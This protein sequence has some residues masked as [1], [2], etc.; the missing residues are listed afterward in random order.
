MKL[1]FKALMLVLLVLLT[2]GNVAVQPSFAS[3][4]PAISEGT[5]E[6]GEVAE[7]TGSEGSDRWYIPDWV[8]DLLEKI[9]AMIQKFNDLM[10]GKLIKDALV[11]LG[12]LLIDEALNPLYDAFSKGFLFTPQ[13]AEID[14]VRG[15]WSTVMIISISALF[16]GILYMAIKVFRGK[17]SLNTL[18]KVFI[19]AFIIN[20]FSL[21][22][23]NILNVGLNMLTQ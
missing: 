17:A 2:F 18:L 10:S 19:G 16:L 22:I 6:S 7:E 9:D 8:I 21:T 11:G 14:G 1:K 20:F 5:P 3:S 4:T 23:L 13:I 12:V 15:A